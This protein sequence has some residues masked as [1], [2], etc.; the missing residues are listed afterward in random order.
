MGTKIAPCCL[1]YANLQS[2]SLLLFVGGQTAWTKATD[3]HLSLLFFFS[4]F[5]TYTVGI[6]CHLNQDLSKK[7]VDFKSP[8]IRKLYLQSNAKWD[9]S[10]TTKLSSCI[11][12]CSSLL[13]RF[14]SIKPL[15]LWSKM[16][17][18]S[19]SELVINIFGLYLVFKDRPFFWHKLAQQYIKTNI[20]L[21]LGSVQ[22]LLN[23]FSCLQLSVVF[24]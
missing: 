15:A 2:L 21:R 22:A 17:T 11:Y 12:I 1:I 7:T 18:L 24:L 5:Q 20:C 10:Q 4:L 8:H 6:Q 14:A 9:N 19:G 13:V 23:A 3:T 16:I